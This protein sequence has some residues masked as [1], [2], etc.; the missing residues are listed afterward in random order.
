MSTPEAFALGEYILRDYQE[1]D[2]SKLRDIR[3][4]DGDAIMASMPGPES[5]EM[6]TI[7]RLEV[8]GAIGSQLSEPKTYYVTSPNNL[9][10]ACPKM[11]QDT[12][13]AYCGLIHINDQELEIHDIT[14]DPMYDGEG[15]IHQLLV[16]AE[17]YA[18]DQN[19]HRLYIWNYRHQERQRRNL[20]RRRYWY[21]QDHPHRDLYVTLKP[22]RMC[23]EIKR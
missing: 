21:V 6:R 3:I 12:P 1:G 23:L 15:L 20:E 19:Y 13:V 22:V 8:A 16:A 4:A 2:S 5:A 11:R 14:Q 18:R 9:L 7:I 10:I 17:A